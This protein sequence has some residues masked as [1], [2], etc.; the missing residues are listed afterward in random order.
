MSSGSPAGRRPRT[1]PHAHSD[2][3]AAAA[4]FGGR[5]VAGLVRASRQEVED[6]VG[7]A[8]VGEAMLRL[9]LEVHGRIH[10]ALQA[11]QARDE[12]YGV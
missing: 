10:D 3:A 11:H 8:D 9:L 4:G 7:A 12:R 6:R 2:A 1:P 5:Q